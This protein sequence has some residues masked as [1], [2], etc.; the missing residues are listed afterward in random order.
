VDSQRSQGAKLACLH[1]LSSFVTGAGTQCRTGGLV[2]TRA[3][4]IDKTQRMKVA[5]RV[6]ELPVL[7]AYYIGPRVKGTKPQMGKKK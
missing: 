1:L 7:R 2:E 4:I 6:G 5:G 3:G